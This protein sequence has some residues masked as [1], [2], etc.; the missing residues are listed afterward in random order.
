[1]FLLIVLGCTYKKL[2]TG[3]EIY[4]PLIVK[5]IKLYDRNILKLS[6]DL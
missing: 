6:L 3:E 2:D 5:A 4:G 1:M